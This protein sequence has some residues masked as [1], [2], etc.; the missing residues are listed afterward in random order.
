M[1]SISFIM[2]TYYFFFGAQGSLINVKTFG[3][4][5][6]V[7]PVYGESLKSFEKGA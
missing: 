2:M 1:G 3:N 7:I 5:I 4:V 6:M